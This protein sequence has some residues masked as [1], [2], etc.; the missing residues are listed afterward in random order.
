MKNV[1]RIPDEYILKRWTK[2]AKVGDMIAYCTPNVQEEPKLSMKRKF[3]ELS[4]MFNQLSAKA[5]ESE[6]TYNIAREGCLKIIGDVEEKL[7]SLK[8]SS[9]KKSKISFDVNG[10]VRSEAGE[11]TS[12]GS[13]CPGIKVKGLKPKPK[14]VR[15]GGK[16]IKNGLERAFTSKR[17]K[18]VSSN[19]SE[20][21]KVNFT[22]FV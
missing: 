12:R 6:E 15:A 22:F 3:K 10:H 14:T 21:T 17:Q 5:A 9:A 16:R 11:G 1:Q 18:K 20:R 8:T 4:I 19:K 13:V 2:D 7:K